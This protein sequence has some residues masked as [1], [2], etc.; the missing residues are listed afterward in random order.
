MALASVS[1]ISPYSPCAAPYIS[2]I[3]SMTY[4]IAWTGPARKGY[5]RLDAQAQ[6]RVLDAVNALALTPRP[7]NSKKLEPKSAGRYRLAVTYRLRVVYSINDAARV[8]TILD[9]STRE[10]AY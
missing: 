5:D 8:V 6:R 2:Y 4:E 7:Q 3:T 1:Q 10:G 9:A